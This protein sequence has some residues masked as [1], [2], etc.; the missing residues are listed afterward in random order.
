MCHKFDKAEETATLEIPY[1]E[2]NVD[3]ISYGEKNVE[4]ISRIHDFKPSFSNTHTMLS[5][6]RRSGCCA[7]HLLPRM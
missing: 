3:L 4:I 5:Q 7:P 6:R 2:K 1:A